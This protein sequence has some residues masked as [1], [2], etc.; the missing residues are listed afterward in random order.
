MLFGPRAE[1]RCAASIRGQW[2][3]ENRPDFADLLGAA[4]PGPQWPQVPGPLA[5]KLFATLLLAAFTLLAMR[6]AARTRRWAAY[7]PIV[8]LLLAA[9][10]ISGCTTGP[11]GTPAGTYPVTVTA[12]SGTLTHS[13]IVT[14]IV[15]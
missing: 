3:K 4:A 9:T 12:T 5:L 15:Q 14:V 7:L 10:V 8:L 2:R 13:V 1:E 6:R 11:Q